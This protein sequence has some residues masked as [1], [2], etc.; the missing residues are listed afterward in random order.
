MGEAGRKLDFAQET[1]GADFGG[2]FWPQHFDSHLAVVPKIARQKYHRH[3]AVAELAVNSVA[4]GKSV[5][6]TVLQPDHGARYLIS[7]RATSSRSAI[8][9]GTYSRSAIAASI[10]VERRADK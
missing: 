5:F 4:A 9:W 6:E 3:A 7:R 10:L 1:F 8:E 2:D